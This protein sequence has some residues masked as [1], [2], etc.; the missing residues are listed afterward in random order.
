VRGNGSVGEEVE[1]C[2]EIDGMNDGGKESS[3]MIMGDSICCGA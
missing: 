3:S 2:I 1:G